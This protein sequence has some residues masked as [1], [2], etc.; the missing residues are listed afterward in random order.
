MVM[1]TWSPRDGYM[2]LEGKATRHKSCHTLNHP[3]SLVEGRP[4]VRCFEQGSIPKRRA[5]ACLLQWFLREGAEA[6]LGLRKDYRDVGCVCFFFVKF[7][8]C[9]WVHLMST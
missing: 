2:N 5:F 7:L 1:L 9:V 4:V 3:D 8:L 6:M